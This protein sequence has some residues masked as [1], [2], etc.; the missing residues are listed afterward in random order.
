MKN[1]V[2]DLFIFNNGVNLLG[3]DLVRLSDYDCCV[4]NFSVFGIKKYS[5]CRM[6][7]GCC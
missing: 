2:V 1:L 5:N 6:L 7:F 4:F 3:R